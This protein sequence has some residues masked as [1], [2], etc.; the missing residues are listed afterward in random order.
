MHKNKLID[1]NKTRAPHFALLCCCSYKDVRSGTCR[2]LTLTHFTYT[3]PVPLLPR[4]TFRMAV[5]EID[6]ILQVKQRIVNCSSQ[7][8]PTAEELGLMLASGQL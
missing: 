5:A 7:E 8:E 6:S 1:M 3:M 2:T 4:P